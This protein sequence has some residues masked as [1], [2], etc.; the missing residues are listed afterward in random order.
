MTRSCIAEKDGEVFTPSKVRHFCTIRSDTEGTRKTK[1]RDCLTKANQSFLDKVRSCN[2]LAHKHR[3]QEV[4]RIFGPV[5]VRC[6]LH[7][8][9]HLAAKWQ[10]WHFLMMLKQTESNLVSRL[11]TNLLRITHACNIATCKVLGLALQTARGTKYLCNMGWLGAISIK[12]IW[13]PTTERSVKGENL[14]VPIRAKI[15]ST[16]WKRVSNR[17]TDVTTYFGDSHTS[18]KKASPPERC[19]N[20]TMDKKNSRA[21]SANH[22]T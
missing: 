6:C 13:K 2:I 17:C 10:E 16:K 4:W 22:E 11:S 20:A 9:F 3:G 5:C 8:A 19:T 7:R 1:N 14:D 18:G 21:R 12:E 15:N